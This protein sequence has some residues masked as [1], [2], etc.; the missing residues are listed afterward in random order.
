MLP[1]LKEF[2]KSIDKIDTVNVGTM[3]PTEWLSTGNY[4]LNKSLSGSF[5]RGFP[6]GRISLVAGPSGA[7]KSFITSN[8]MAEAQKDGF[9]ILVLDSENALDLEY[10]GK[11]GVDTDEDKMTYVQ[12]TTIEDVN[13]VCSEFF[14]NY[15][16]TYGKNSEGSPKVMIVLDSLGMLASKTEIENYEKTHEIKSDQGILAKRRKAMLRLIIGSIARLPIAFV[17]TDHVYPADIMLGDG[18]WTITNSTKFSSSIIGIVTKLK[19]KEDGVVTGVRMRFETYKSRF[20]VIGTKIEL[21]VPYTKGMSPFSGL[22]DMLE[23]MK[24]IA[25]GT[26]PGEKTSYI[27]EVNGERIKFKNESELTHELVSKILQHPNASPTDPRL[28]DEITVSALE[29]I[30]D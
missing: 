5:D 7:G 20:A 25:K 14:S 9:H 29:G 11:I 2:K 12:V 17:M 1:F 19:L 26:V 16:K 4:A 27:C 3:M 24:V 28:E 22:I 8:A 23:E 15:K 30:E 6:L 21:E 10:L 18:A 13:A